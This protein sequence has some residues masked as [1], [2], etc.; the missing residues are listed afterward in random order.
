MD[1]A[2]KNYENALKLNPSDMDTK[3]NLA[4]AKKEKKNK[5]GGGQNNQQQ[6][7]GQQ[8]KQKESDKG[9]ESDQKKEGDQKEDSEKNQPKPKP[10]GMSQEDAQKLLEALK[11]QEQNTQRKVDLQRQKP[12]Q[13]KHEKDW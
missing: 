1:S 8:E 2:I 9:K 3:Y 7:Q 4:M 6:N 10:G 13:K 11:N 12:D 5:G